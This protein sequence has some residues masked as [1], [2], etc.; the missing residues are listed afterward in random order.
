MPLLKIAKKAIVEVAPIVARRPN[1]LLLRAA[2]RNDQT[3][4]KANTASR[5]TAP[6]NP[7]SSAMIVRMKSVCCSGTYSC[8]DWMPCR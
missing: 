1:Q 2:T 3:N 5:P 4:R 7:N 8:W 6:M